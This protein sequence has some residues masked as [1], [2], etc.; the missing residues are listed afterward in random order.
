MLCYNYKYR[1]LSTFVS[2]QCHSAPPL[3][4]TKQTPPSPIATP[5]ASDRMEMDLNWM[6]AI[7]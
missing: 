3:F 1:A 4:L 5:A 7:E 6:V 2:T